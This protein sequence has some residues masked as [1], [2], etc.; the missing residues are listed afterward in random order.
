MDFKD[1]ENG[2]IPKNP[3]ILTVIEISKK[4][5]KYGLTTASGTYNIENNNFKIPR[6]RIGKKDNMDSFAGM[7]IKQ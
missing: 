7:I 3:I 5:Y 6:I 2:N 4:Y 1:L